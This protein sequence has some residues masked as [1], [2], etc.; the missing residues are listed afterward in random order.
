MN[1]PLRPDDAD[2]WLDEAL[3]SYVEAEPLD[4]L[5]ARLLRSVQGGEQPT[6]RRWWK[7]A[8]AA[9]PVALAVV[10]VAFVAMLPSRLELKLGSPAPAAPWMAY[11]F[12]PPHSRGEAPRVR[13]GGARPRFRGVSSRGPQVKTPKRDVFPSPSPLNDEERSLILLAESAPAQLPHVQLSP[14]DPTSIRPITI[15]PIEQAANER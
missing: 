3:H 7:I 2:R 15:K 6:R 12:A 9:A 1:Q 11:S 5:E 13:K 4:G 8:L 10:G 14:M